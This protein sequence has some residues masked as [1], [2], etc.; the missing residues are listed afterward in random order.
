VRY[1]SWRD[2]LDYCVWLEKR[3]GS[4]PTSTVG[5][6]LASGARVTLPSEAEWEASASAGGRLYPWAGELAPVRAN[7]ADSGRLGPVRVGE[8]GAGAT[9]ANVND[10]IGNVAE[11]TRSEYRPYP[12]EP[13][14]GREDTTAVAKSR[15]IRGGSFY[16]GP[17]LLRI[18]SRRAADPALGYD[19]VG[20]RVAIAPPTLSSGSGPTSGAP[21]PVTASPPPTGK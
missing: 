21:P 11:W 5:S 13:G 4:M 8:F 16:D 15:V 18:T 7:Y 2:A 1:V 19:F 10:L 14:D 6:L 20:F 17:S 3:L 12:Y 9:Q